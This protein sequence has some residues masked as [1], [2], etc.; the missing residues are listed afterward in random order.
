MARID[1]IRKLREQGYGVFQQATE[2]LFLNTH[3]IMRM[4]KRFGK[5]NDE[6]NDVVVNT[7]R[8]RDDSPLLKDLKSFVGFLKREGVVRG[9][10]KFYS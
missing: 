9:Y 5:Y 2:T 1:M 3:V 4:G 7:N 10:S 6:T 8:R